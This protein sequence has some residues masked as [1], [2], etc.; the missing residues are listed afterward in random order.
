MTLSFR[1]TQVILWKGSNSQSPLGY[2]NGTYLIWGTFS[3]VFKACPA[4]NVLPMNRFSFSQAQL[5][6]YVTHSNRTARASSGNRGQ[7]ATKYR[8]ESRTWLLFSKSIYRRDVA[9]CQYAQKTC[10]HWKCASYQIR[11]IWGQSYRS[12]FYDQVEFYYRLKSFRK[13]WNGRILF[14]T[15][16]RTNHLFQRV[17][18][19]V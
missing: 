14:V 10:G 11:P 1:K 5:R 6:C 19:L 7:Q 3:I 13:S 18:P 16:F 12:K 17:G 4:K 2:C 15:H 8:D 9:F